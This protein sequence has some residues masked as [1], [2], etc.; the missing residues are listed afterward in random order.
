MREKE[1][2][3]C[4]RMHIWASKTQKLPGP[5]S[6]PWTPAADCSRDSAS[7]HRQL[8]ASVAGPP[9]DQ[10]LD[11]HLQSSLFWILQITHG[12]VSQ[13]KNIS[14][15][16][17]SCKWKYT[18]PSCRWSFTNIFH[19][20]KICT[21]TIT[22]TVSLFW[23]DLP[24]ENDTCTSVHCLECY[25]LKIWTNGV[26]HAEICVQWGNI[27]FHILPLRTTCL[28]LVKLASLSH[29][30]IGYFKCI[31][32]TNVTFAFPGINP[33]TTDQFTYLSNAKLIKWVHLL[34]KSPKF[35]YV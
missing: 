2:L 10:I 22:L 23:Y 26:F 24:N 18:R 17:F 27:S 34:K 1:S 29:W 20:D 33:F 5:L 6:G 9:L 14:K 11:P 28:S 21:N 3:E 12:T 35:Q 19:K 30:S 4:V 32:C 7:L 16:Q 15:E 8:S 31:I 13:Q 25:A